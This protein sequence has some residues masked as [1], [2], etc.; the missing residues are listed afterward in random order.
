MLELSPLLTRRRTRRRPRCRPRP[1]C[2]GRSRCRSP[3]G[4]RTSAPSRRKA[5]G[6]WSMTATVWPRSSRLRARVEPTR[7]Q[8]MITKCTDATLT[9]RR[10]ASAAPRVAVTT[11]RDALRRSAVGVAPGIRVVVPSLGR[12]VKRRA[13]RPRVRSDRLAETLL[14][15][16]VA[17]PVF[18]SDAL[19]SVAYAPDEIFLTLRLAGLAAYASRRGVGARRRRGHAHRRRARTGRTC[20]PTPRGGGDYEVATVN[21][22][23]TAGLD[24]RQRAARRLRAHGRGVGLLRRAVRRVGAPGPARARGRRRRRRSSPLLTAMN[25]RGVRESGHGV[26]GARRTS[27]WS[28]SS[29][30]RVVGLPP[31]LARRP[32]GGRERRPGRCG[33]GRLDAGPRSG[34][35]RRSCCC[36][37]SPPAAPR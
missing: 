26:R 35:P 4:P 10:P 20:T 30:W 29:A 3:G 15:K 16:R 33:R 34:W 5:S 6:F 31:V 36:A 21:L 7:P 1:G 27:S 37:R 8:P 28:R 32:A 24:R 25:L 23:P 17:L 12:C 11:P 13:A 18:A 19:S 14:P 22:G 9:A 2:R